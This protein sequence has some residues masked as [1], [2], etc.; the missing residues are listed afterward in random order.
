MTVSLVQWLAV[1]DIFNCR[2]SLISITRICNLTRN[3]VSMFETLFL[4]YHYF[5]SAYIPFLAFLYVFVLLYARGDI[6]IKS[7]PRKLKKKPLSLP[8]ES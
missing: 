7:G 3:F 8:L 5:E 4:S 1:I 6:E 2:S